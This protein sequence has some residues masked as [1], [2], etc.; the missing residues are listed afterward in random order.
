MLTCVIFD[1]DVKEH[2]LVLVKTLYPK[3]NILPEALH[4]VIHMPALV[5]V[6]G[7]VRMRGVVGCGC[8]WGWVGVD[9]GGRGGGFTNR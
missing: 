7:F 1:A 6:C 2:I 3:L 4:G 5:W 9:A 8:A